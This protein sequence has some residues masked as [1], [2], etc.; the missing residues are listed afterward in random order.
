MPKVQPSAAASSGRLGRG[1]RVSTSL[2]EINVVPLVDVML[3][4]LI[5]FMITAPM[6]QRGIDVNLPVQSRAV[7]MTGE[8]VEITIP[9]S[10]RLN[11]FVNI[12][13]EPVRID[14]LGERVRQ[15]LEGT[16][17]KD[18][19][20]RGDAGVTLQEVSDVFDRLLAAGVEHVGFE[21]KRPGE[22]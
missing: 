10:Y 18:V 12:G 11:H 4:L 8:R 14:V 1:R 20:L 19:Y 22:K 21:T 9:L 5:I 6:I 15:K 7:Q 16:V 17:K 2:A 3:V 13:K